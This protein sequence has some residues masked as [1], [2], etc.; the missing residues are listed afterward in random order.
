[1]ACAHLIAAL[2]STL[3]GVKIANK[4]M[5]GEKTALHFAAEK[6]ATEV[7]QVTLDH[8]ALRIQVDEH[9]GEY[10]I[11]HSDCRDQ[12]LF[13]QMICMCFD[14]ACVI[15]STGPADWTCDFLLCLR[16]CWQLVPKLIKHQ[17]VE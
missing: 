5:G 11:T 9:K 1:M 4:L 3:L 15:S 14:S 8:W 12:T 10:V 17:S 2:V 13:L 7:I 6:G 16:H